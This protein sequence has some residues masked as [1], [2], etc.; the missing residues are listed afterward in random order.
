[1]MNYW[2][3]SQKQ[4]FKQEFEGGYMWSPKEN[5]NGTQ[6]HY[7]NNMT[8][9]QPGDVVFSFAKGLITEATKSAQDP[10]ASANNILGL[11]SAESLLIVCIS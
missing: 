3:V 1:M 8:L 5:K 6:S 7:Y 9:V 10:T 2:W 11:D 4:T